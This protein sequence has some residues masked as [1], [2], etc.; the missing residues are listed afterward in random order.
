MT[1]GRRLGR[2]GLVVGLTASV[3]L[4]AV[5]ALLGWLGRPAGTA[6]GGRGA[7]PARSVSSS[8]P[9]AADGAAASEGGDAGAVGGGGFARDEAGAAEAALAYAAASQRWLYLREDQVAEA[10]AQIAAPRAWPRSN[11]DCGFTLTNTF[12][13]ATS[14][15]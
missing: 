1:S 12:S 11:V 10:V 15:G 2:R 9:L 8:A 4:L 13:T 14:T 6:A 3:A 5:A 7:A